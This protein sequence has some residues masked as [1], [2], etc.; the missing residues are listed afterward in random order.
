MATA[1]KLTNSN[2]SAVL[3]VEDYARAKEFYEDRL[4]LHVEDMPDQEGVGMLHAGNGS[5][6]LLYQRERTK[7]EHTVL[8]FEVD[9][10]D[11]TVQDLRSHGIE[12]EEYDMPGIHTE[13]GVARMGNTASA[14]FTDTEGNIISI[15]QM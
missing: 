7:A 3:P 4:G 13:N 11:S 8:G 5:R 15:N 1:T 14:W 9:D 2:A 10:I 12:F 6:V